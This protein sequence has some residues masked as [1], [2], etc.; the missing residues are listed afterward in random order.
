MK[1]R[2][3]PVEVQWVD[4]ASQ[5]GWRDCESLEGDNG[6]V[7]IRTIGY[8]TRCSRKV[9]QVVQSR[10]VNDSDYLMKVAETI[11][12]PRQCVRKI[13]PIRGLK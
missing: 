4:T 11:T 7:E 2:L 10:H 3:Q 9:V 13:T 1:S 5:H 12:I 8:L 6:T